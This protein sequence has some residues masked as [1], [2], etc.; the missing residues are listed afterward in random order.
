MFVVH[1]KV[2]KVAVN[3]EFIEYLETHNIVTEYQSGFPNDISCE[4]MLQTVLM[5]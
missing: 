4:N 1:K 5:N 3:N 2:L